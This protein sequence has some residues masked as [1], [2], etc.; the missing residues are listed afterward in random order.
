MKGEGKETDGR[1]TK[2]HDRRRVR[3]QPAVESWAVE[4]ADRP[5]R[6]TRAAD[7][8]QVSVQPGSSRAADESQ[9][10]CC[11]AA[12]GRSDLLESRMAAPP[13]RCNPWAATR[14]PRRTPR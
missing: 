7:R 1:V 13:S 4:G 2:S 12:A 10:K 8:G 5:P 14:A 9:Y 6:R 11:K 3:V